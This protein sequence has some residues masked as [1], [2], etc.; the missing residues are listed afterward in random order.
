MDYFDL[1]CDTAYECLKTGQAFSH[2]NLAISSEKGK[3][4][5]KWTQVFAVWIKDD[6]FKPFLTYK[7]TL[8]YF[9]NQLDLCKAGNL[10][11]IFAVEGGAAIENI[12]NLYDMH[13]DGVKSITLTWN[14]KNKIASGVDERG[15]LTD[16]GRQV[17]HV[18]NNLK[19]ATDLSHLNEESFFDAI[20]LARYPIATHSNCN[21]VY[22]HKRNLSDVQLL[23]IAEKGGII[24]ICPYPEFT[25]LD[26]FWGVYRNIL[27]MLKL[28]IGK[29]IAFGS[30]FD[31]AKMSNNLSNISKIPDLV[32]FLQERG[33]SDEL[34]EQIFY[35]NAANYFEKL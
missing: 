2:N 31:G 22:M 5:N 19:I 33:I 15:G 6:V 14:S 32:A 12:D 10:T 20:K 4:F 17:I 16:Y 25:G 11:P 1:H 34:C 28:G 29:N 9:K 27:H 7:K 35:K 24:G 21:E 8:E 30:D 26:S 3:A 23:K 13:R 18:M